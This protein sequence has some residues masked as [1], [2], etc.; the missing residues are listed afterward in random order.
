MKTII[1]PLNNNSSMFDTTTTYIDA[2]KENLK[3]LFLTN[4]GDR[5]VRRSKIGL[6]LNS[7]F[8]E[9]DRDAAIQMIKLQLSQ[10]IGMYFTNIRIDNVTEIDPESNIENKSISLN[11]YFT[12]TSINVSDVV[13]IS[14]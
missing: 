12:D 6:S 14:S 13:N 3:N 4:S 2:V 9:N 5:V 8:F 7:I 1:T 11:I 10:N